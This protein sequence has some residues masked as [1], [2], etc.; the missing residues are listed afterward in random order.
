MGL[1]VSGLG[2]TGFASVHNFG[3]KRLLFGFR[4]ADIGFRAVSFMPEVCSVGVTTALCDSG[5][6]LALATARPWKAAAS[7]I[8]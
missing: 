7:T 5:P 1:G 6:L 8:K 4:V 2:L 3:C